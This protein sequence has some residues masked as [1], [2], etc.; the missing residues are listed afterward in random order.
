VEVFVP[1]RLKDATSPYLR[2]HMDNPV[3]WYPWGAEAF[4]RAAREDKPILLSVG[5][6]ACHWCHVMAHESFEDPET[7]A[8]MNR[9]F[10]NIKVDREEHPEVDQIYQHALS[11]FEDHGGW[12]LT[13][14]LLPSGEPFYGG[15]YFPP[16]DAYGRPSFRR[17]LGSLAAAYRQN[18]GDV[19]A[20]AQRLV[21]AL[22][23]L[24]SRGSAGETAARL[25]P[26]VASRMAARLATR[27][28][29]RE[30]GFEG[31]PKFPNPTALSLFV[32]AY[33]RTRDAESAQPALL[34]LRKMADG[35]IYDHLGGGF[36]RYS[37]DPMWLVP[38]FEKMLYDNAQLLRLYAEAN[39]IFIE[40]GQPEPAERAAEVI[41]ETHGW[42]ERE[43]RDASGGL[44]AAQDADSEGVEGKYFVWS[45]EEVAAVL[46]PESA[47]LFC[48]AYD[49][50]PGGNWN[51][52]H[53]HGEKGKSIPHIV[54]RPENPQE[55]AL[56]LAA[57]KKLLL[58]RQERVPPGTDD[59]VLCSWNGLAITGLAEA[60]RLLGEPRY[61]AA[62]RRTADF[63]LAR[64]RD[65]AG[66]LLRTFKGGVA[67]LPA[68]LD[69]H[70]FLAEGLYH[71]A[72]ASHDLSYLLV[73][74]EIT[75]ALLRDF[76]DAERRL[77]YLGPEESDGVRLPTRPVSFQ[78]G[79]IP[80]GLSV[81]CMNLLRLSA[82]V[83]DAS[84]ERYRDIAERTLLGLSEQALRSPFGLSN[85]VA[86]L[87]LLQHGLTTA[88][89]VDPGLSRPRPDELS[90]SPAAAELLR[91]TSERYVPDVFVVLCHSGSQ[92]PESLDHLRKG[93][94][95]RAGGATAYVCHGPRCSAPISTPASLSAEL[96][97]P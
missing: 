22:N 16:R 7:A 81:A 4:A 33:G 89:V 83:D 93:K 42:L 60:G 28:D 88:V 10:V 2:Q 87:D 76:Y 34:T 97:R 63:V 5:Y 55:K 21:A 75:E 48:R 27:I 91:A 29:R 15:T 90:P 52:P 9:D 39:R 62:A 61:V 80:S 51:D 19:V 49:I 50:R 58:A 59:K 79:A 78:D 47:L 82:L 37:T 32:R 20:Q 70:A 12:P 65:P 45:P 77:F 92:L 13:M 1:N 53:G 30:G 40:L 71:L 64:M 31:A 23:E 57:R 69:D 25:P 56:L 94:T 54:E 35:G 86:A 74:R 44:Y 85:L 43:M 36:A 17:V 11:L 14:F 41:A 68:T 24:E 3:D 67:R 96:S 6:S 72:S 8:Q 18:H 73:M 26:D 38:H 84:R 66:R 95:A 46:P